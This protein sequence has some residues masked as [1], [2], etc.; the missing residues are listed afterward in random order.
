[1]TRHDFALILVDKAAQDE[2]AVD[3]LLHDYSVADEG[4]PPLERTQMREL[5]LR[6]R[7]WVEKQIHLG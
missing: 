2:V 4:L 3:R 7:D 1:M 5:V 6:L